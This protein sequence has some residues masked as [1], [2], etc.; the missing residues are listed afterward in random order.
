MVKLTKIA[1]HILPLNESSSIDYPFLSGN[2]SNFIIHKISFRINI[3]AQRETTHFNK[4]TPYFRCC[5]CLYSSSLA[6]F[7]H[8]SI[9]M[10]TTA[11][12]ARQRGA[13]TVPYQCRGGGGGYSVWK[14]V[15]TA[16]RPSKSFGCRDLTWT[17]K[18]GSPVIESSHAG[19]VLFLNVTI[20][21]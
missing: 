19:A 18:E 11:T 1:R 7:Q 6:S 5:E 14:R 3:S 4:L 9:N 15:P 13:R 8:S 2:P 17:K 16:V 10:P 21:D 20:L 12:G